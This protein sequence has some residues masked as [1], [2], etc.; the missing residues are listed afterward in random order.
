[1]EI[2]TLDT[3]LSFVQESFGVKLSKT[4]AREYLS[5]SYLS[6]RVAQRV[7]PTASV[8]AHG[9]A[10]I[11]SDWIRELRRGG[12]FPTS[13]GLLGSMDFTYTRHTTTTLHTIAAKGRFAR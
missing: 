9:L 8:G 11:C 12:I 5:E 13:P 10:K 1:M 7:A 4:T 6:S 3:V 2:V